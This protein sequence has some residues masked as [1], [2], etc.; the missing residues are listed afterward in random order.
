MEK[1]LDVNLAELD[2]KLFRS[3]Q[4]LL[5]YSVL[6]SIEFK[7]FTLYSYL[8]KGAQLLRKTFESRLAVTEMFNTIEKELV[9]LFVQ[10][11]FVR[12]IKEV[13]TLNF[14]IYNI[15]PTYD[16]FF[17]YF[18]VPLAA[19]FLPVFLDINIVA[20]RC[21]RSNNYNPF[22]QFFLKHHHGLRDRLQSVLLGDEWVP[23][24]NTMIAGALRF[25]RAEVLLFEE[26]VQVVELLLLQSERHP[27]ILEGF[28]KFQPDKDV[29]SLREIHNHYLEAVK[30]QP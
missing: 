22:V 27:S 4:A 5:L 12:G 1:G 21:H 14:E 30:A 11:S 28:L 2:R 29:Q 7:I 13:S 26:F 20:D 18:S 3:E 25:L 19:K 24:V 16:Y 15:E 17:F 9:P 23:H 10:Q 8:R 6:H